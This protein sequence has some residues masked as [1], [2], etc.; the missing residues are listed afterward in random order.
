MQPTTHRQT[1]IIVL[2]VLLGLG[3]GIGSYTFLYAQGWSYLTNNPAACA[4]C[5]IMHD[6]YEAWIKSS[7]RAVATCNDCHTPT[8]LIAKYYT[9]ADH[10]FWHSYAFT[11][12]DFH[13]PIR[14]KARSQAVTESACRTCHQTITQAIDPP[15]SGR[16][17]SE[18]LSCI[19]CHRTVGHPF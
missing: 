3:L 15:Q 12:G 18:A 9:K 13:E 19:R 6:H 1:A 16:H 7:H 11:T 8:N 5:H 14:M 10:G 2:G 4:N 17:G